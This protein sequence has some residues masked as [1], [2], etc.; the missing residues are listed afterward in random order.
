MT[1]HTRGGYLRITGVTDIES[2]CMRIAASSGPQLPPFRS[3]ADR[4]I[5]L[6]CVYDRSA[7]WPTGAIKRFGRRRVVVLIC[8]DFGGP[9]EARAPEARRCARKLRDWARWVMVHGG[10]GDAAHYRAAAQAAQIVNHAVVIETSSDRAR[11]WA[12]FLGCPATLLVLPEAG[13]A[14]PIEPERGK[15]Q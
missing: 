4:K 2:A 9:G 6:A 8:D 3:V 15:M 7:P 12:A 10:A 5:A 14:H 1:A 13:G 11:E